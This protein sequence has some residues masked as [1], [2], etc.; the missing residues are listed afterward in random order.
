MDLFDKYVLNIENLLGDMPSKRFAYSQKTEK[1]S[2]SPSFITLKDAKAELGGGDTQ[3]LG[4]SV[5]TSTLDIQNETVLYGEDLKD[6]SANVPFI[7]IVFIK[8]K[9]ILEDEQTIY[10]VIKELEYLKYNVNIS[11][12]MSRASSRNLR[13]EVRVSKSA[14]KLGLCFESVGNTLISEYLK[15]P[16]VQKVKI[17]FVSG[18]CAKFDELHKIAKTLTTAQNALNH[19]MDNVVIDCKTCNLKSICDEVEGMR[20][21]HIKTAKGMQ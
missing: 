11:G 3:S 4:F 17:V 8:I 10:N 20:E 13:E 19:I 2:K 1:F 15:H 21:L 12:F 6:L 9:D 14:V 7:K 18:E 5:Q 16:N